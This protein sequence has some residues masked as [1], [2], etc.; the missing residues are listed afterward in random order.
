MPRKSVTVTSTLAPLRSRIVGRL[1]ALE[2]GVDRHEDGA[3]L[4]QAEERRRS[5]GAL[6]GA[7]IATRSPGSTPAATSAGAEGARL[8]EQLGVGEPEVAVDDRDAV[9]E[10]LGGRGEQRRDGGGRG[11]RRRSPEDRV[12]DAHEPGQVAAHDLADGLLGQ[13]PRARCT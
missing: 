8:V 7:Q 2:A 3:G 10:P 5:S 4:E 6:F 9:A 13:R 11:R 12:L 1:G